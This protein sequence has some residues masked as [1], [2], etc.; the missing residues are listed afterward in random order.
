M[1][2]LDGSAGGGQLLRSAMAL[3]AITGRSFRMD[4]VR[5]GRSTPGLR[6]QHVAAVRL[7]ADLTSADVEGA[8][9]GSD[10]IAFDPGSP[11]PGTYEVDVGTAGS[12]ELVFDAVLPLA[13]SIDGRLAITARGGTDVK[14]AP[15][16]AYYEHVK[17]PL[18]RRLGVEVALDVHRRGFYPAG[19]GSAT[20]YLSPSS[21]PP[22]DLEG[23]GPLRGARVYSTATADLADA[24]VAERQ[25]DAATIAIEGANVAVS[26]R[27]I[28]Y[29]D[30]DSAGSALVV[31]LEYDTS[32]AG[33]D[34]L[35]ERGKPA[36]DVARSATDEAIDFHRG[37]AVVDPYTA[38]QLLLP[39]AL[40]GGRIRI[41]EE[42]DHVRTNRRLVRAFGF[43]V[44][45]ERTDDALVLSA[46]PPRRTD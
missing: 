19:G 12:V 28:Q 42:T 11:E 34:A 37:N 10:V 27:T 31:R 5:G 25:A 4:G 18:L 38:D 23:R 32:V 9:V 39:L 41:P 15:P 20:C 16:T 8:S 24:D 13:C 46:E 6:P 36:E 22:F 43:D 44:A 21:P 1:I 14:W 3:S 33:F 35:G 7:L 40:V 29:V 17:L 2:E 30:A 45:V 26:E